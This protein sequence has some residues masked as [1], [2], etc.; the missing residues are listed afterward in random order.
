MPEDEN[1][2]SPAGPLVPEISNGEKPRPHPEAEERPK[3]FRPAGL[4]LDDLRVESPIYKPPEQPEGVPKSSGGPPPRIPGRTAKLRLALAGKS[5]QHPAPGKSEP[6][7]NAPRV[8]VWESPRRT[9]PG[10]LI[11]LLLLIAGFLATAFSNH[12]I[13]HSWDEALYLEPGEKAAEWVT[14]VLHGDHD[15][16][17]ARGIDESW[18]NVI[19][20]S[21]DPLHPEIAP[22]PKLLS[23]I[24][25]RWFGSIDWLNPII[26]QRLPNAAIFG[27]TLGFIFLLGSGAFGKTA[28]VFSALIYG[29]MPRVFGHAHIAASETPLAFASVFL[30]WAFLLALRR[31]WAA[32]ITAF[33]FALAFDTKITALFLPVALI[34]WSQLYARRK[35]GANVCA[36][37]LLSPVFIVAMWPWLWH[38]AANKLLSYFAYYINHQSTAVFYMGLMWGLARPAAPWHYPFVITAVSLP[39][40]ILLLLI[41]GLV[42]AVSRLRREPVGVLF[43]LLAMMPICISALPGSPKYDGERLFFSAFAFLALIAAGGLGAIL[44]FL[45]RRAAEDRNPNLR[46]II[47]VGASALVLWGGFLVV[48]THPNE[49]NFFNLFAGGTS[50]AAERGFETSYWGEAVNEEVCA[51][52]NALTKPGDRVQVLS[53]NELVFTH[54]QKW[55]RLRPDIKCAGAEP[56]FNWIVLQVRQGMMAKYEWMLHVSRKPVKSFGNDGA[57]RIEIFKGDAQTANK[58]SGTTSSK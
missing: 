54:L 34:A 26:A 6:R 21:E 19:Q 13:G 31:P 44:D 4:T 35:Y 17:S 22:I 46:R 40:W 18:G 38:G 27:L 15:A 30:T 45:K 25:S 58:D 10:P 7:A 5:P 57:S 36:L 47:P 33:A 1:E 28:G 16:L 49:L 23:G 43:L 32:I 56:P 53:L 3:I 51:A 12:G 29:L 2:Q 24:G 55:G 50:G 41:L 42:R 37:A 11:F 9:V 48:R 8:E 14:D 39:I 20:G 52:L